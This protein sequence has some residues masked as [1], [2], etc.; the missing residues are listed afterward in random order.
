[1]RRPTTHTSGIKIEGYI[2]EV[3]GVPWAIVYMA[4]MPRQD[5]PKY[6]FKTRLWK[7]RR[8]NM[9]RTFSMTP[10]RSDRKSGKAMKPSLR[11]N[12]RLKFAQKLKLGSR[13]EL[14]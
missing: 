2:P 14:C 8:A 7:P 12:R 6:Y 9:K 13:S 4:L 10:D 5:T 11:N 3:T 1:M